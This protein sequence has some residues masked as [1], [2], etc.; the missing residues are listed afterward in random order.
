ME[1]GKDGKLLCFRFTAK[2]L[3]FPSFFP[4]GVGK[5]REGR[6]ARSRKQK[7]GSKAKKARPKVKKP[8]CF[9]ASR[10]EGREEN[11]KKGSTDSNYLELT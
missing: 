6:E 11:R 9:P 4:E 10:R 1:A 7:G 5:F 8:I 3:F 2:L